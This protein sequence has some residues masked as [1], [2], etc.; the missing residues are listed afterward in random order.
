MVTRALRLAG[1]RTRVLMAVMLAVPLAAV[2]AITGDGARAAAALPANFQQ[3]VIYSG[4]TQPTNVEFSPDGRVFVAEKSG[5]IKVFDSFA[6]TTPSIYADL[7]PEVH[8]LWDRGMLGLALHPNFPAD[9]RVYV[10]YAYNGVIGGTHPKW[11]SSNGT[12][13]QCP[14]PPGATSDGCVASGRLSVLSPDAD[15]GG[16][17]SER[18]LVEDW[19]QQYP[20]HSVGTVAFG[21]DGMLY[22]GGG[23]GAS[24]NYADYGQDAFTSSDVTPDNPCGD[25][26]SPVGTALTPPSAEG[27]ALRAQD[28]RTT[29]DPTTLDGGIIRIDPETGKAAAGNPTTTGDDN[30]KRLIAHGVRNPYRFTFR[31]GT[32]ELW[33]G[34]VGWNTSEE[35]NRIR[36]PT[37]NLTNLGW[38]CYEGAGKQA[39]YDGA[40]LNLCK[41]L[42]ASA[43]AAPYYTYRHDAKV[44]AGET[45]GTGSSSVTGMAF[46]QNG[47][48]PA[49]YRGA[50]FFTDYNRK[51]VWAMKAGTNGLPSPSKIET[52]AT[53]TGGL[54]E[55]QA[56]PGGD[57]FGVDIENGRILRW[58]YNGVNNP[59]VAA[60]KPDKTTGALPLTVG[61]DGTVSSDADGE[62]LTYSWDLDGDG[63]YGDS[64]AAKPA[65]TY[66]DRASVTVRLRVT[67]PRGGTDTASTVITAGS[68]PPTASIDT[69]A[70]GT[71]WTVGE[72]I[73]FSGSAT[74]AE[75]GPLPPSALDWKLIM[76]H[77]PSNCHE[78]QIT[79]QS[80]SGG[81]FT[82]PDHEYPS[83]LE[84][85]LTVTDSDG[86]T[87][88]KSLRLD[89]K[90]VDL[91][92][93]SNPPGFPLTAL[94]ATAAAPFNRTVIVGSS[95]SISAPTGTQW[96]NEQVYQFTGWSDGGAATHNITAP[97]TPATYTASFARKPNL[98]LNRPATASSVYKA[99]AEAAKSFDGSMSTRWSSKYSSPQW[100]RTDLGSTRRVSRFILRWEA[101]YGKNYQIQV[102][103]N[104]STWT[105]VVTR[106]NGDGKLDT[107]YFTPQ[108]ARYVRMYGTTRATN[109]GYSLWEFEVYDG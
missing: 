43:V 74:D 87:D 39:G 84:L 18:V 54:V 28:V 45:C 48:Y 64:T 46:D 107:G 93:S 17:I 55:L 3:K 29:A 51:C 103:P 13:D 88:T 63:A 10:L 97:A 83:W 22:A 78:H 70:T 19:C 21:Q 71:K 30:A 95:V 52:F 79:G 90:T 75:D 76:H 53:G 32:N 108:D 38:P 77:C 100:I 91:T 96:Q 57:I 92:L 37:A 47:A 49:A 62:A 101:A 1:R 42:A 16:A 2:L 82:A 7:R 33:A 80:G 56:G 58:V 89:P 15:Q 99:G 60:I 105:T 26:P 102:S 14:T 41:N 73:G 20:S 94:D 11:G 85:R 25:P 5:L 24:F 61:F 69:P 36:S 65:K 9:P 104:G 66:T 98:A 106:T 6:D 34:D 23:D 59:P 12:D 40:G 67:D 35:I 27:G 50:L 4:L 8:N 86:L 72:Q 109:Y 31:P 68:S 81:E 44:V